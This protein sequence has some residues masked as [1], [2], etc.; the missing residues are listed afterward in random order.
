M[1]VSDLKD[2][3]DKELVYILYELQNSNDNGNDNGVLQSYK[4]VQAEC[5]AKATQKGIMDRVHI[6]FPQEG[7][8]RSVAQR[9]SLE[10]LT[11]NERLRGTSLMKT[12]VI[13]TKRRKC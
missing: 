6:Y 13:L 1:S 11:H 8:G 5:E 9:G 7:R 12:M 2:S 4:V 10:G 3:E